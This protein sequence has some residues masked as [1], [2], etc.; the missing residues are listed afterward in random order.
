MNLRLSG[1]QTRALRL[2]A[3]RLSLKP[4][5]SKAGVVQVLK[6]VCGVQAQDAQA[7]ALAVR[8]RSS[9]LL[10]RDVEQARLQDRSVIRTWCQRG[11]L[12]FLAVEDYAWLLP[13][14]GP[15][16]AAGSPSRELE[17]GWDGDTFEKGIRLL[18]RALADQGPLT[19]EEISGLL[20]ATA[21]RRRGQAPIHLIQRAAFAGLLARGLTT[22]A[23]QHSCWWKIG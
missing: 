6:A 9:G 3:Q 20:T 13:L 21:S 10:A 2:R 4:A 17:L 19:R 22:M 14:L 8:V 12:H 18:K 5:D 7:A 1:D 15:L 16:F 23:S 11:T